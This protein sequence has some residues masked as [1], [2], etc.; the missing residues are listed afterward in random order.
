MPGWTP[1]MP[2]R[3]W[4]KLAPTALGGQVYSVEFTRAI[5]RDG[6]PLQGPVS[7]QLA[8]PERPRFEAFPSEAVTLK[9]GE[10]LDIMSSVPLADI[11]VQTSGDLP[12]RATLDGQHIKLAFPRFR[13]GAETQVTVAAAIS[14]QGAPLES[15]MTF[16]LRTPAAMEMPKFIPENKAQAVRLSSR[17]YLEFVEPPRILTLCAAR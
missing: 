3:T 16:S 15:P 10:T 9:Q 7:F 2:T 12:A 4:I 5:G 11:D 17:P 13:Q 14:R 8:L 6:M 1:R